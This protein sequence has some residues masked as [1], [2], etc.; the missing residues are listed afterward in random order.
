[1]MNA[2]FCNMVERF[3]EIER[4]CKIYGCLLSRLKCTPLQ[5][6]SPKGYVKLFKKDEVLEF[7]ESPLFFRT[8]F[9]KLLHFVWAMKFGMEGVL[10][11]IVENQLKNS[12]F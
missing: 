9:F 6:W 3:P 4:S 12:L 7:P 10:E 1:M 8:E 2:M 11:K 5:F